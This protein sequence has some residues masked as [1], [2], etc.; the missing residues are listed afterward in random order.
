MTSVEPNTRRPDGPLTS[1]G[2]HITVDEGRTS[3]FAL[4]I[5]EEGSETAWLISDTVRS[6]ENMR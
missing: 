6:L 3:F 4:S 1:R 5:E 2:Y